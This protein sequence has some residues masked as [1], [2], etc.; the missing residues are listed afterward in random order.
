MK[1]AMSWILVLCAVALNINC[2][3]AFP[4][5]IEQENRDDG[6]MVDRDMTKVKGGFAVPV[7]DKWLFF[8]KQFRNEAAEDIQDLSDMTRIEG[9]VLALPTTRDKK[10]RRVLAEGQGTM[11]IPASKVGTVVLPIDPF[12]MGTVVFANG[13]TYAARVLIPAYNRNR[14]TIIVPRGFGVAEGKFTPA[15]GDSFYYEEGEPDGQVAAT[16]APP[17]AMRTITRSVVDLT[18]DNNGLVRPGSTNL[19]N[20]PRPRSIGGAM[21][22][23]PTL[24]DRPLGQNTRSITFR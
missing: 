11:V 17:L 15:P 2:A 21:E 7:G 19:F 14:A 3:L 16:P 1:L 8:K 12:K 9:G 18:F 24:R 10:G 13:G 5:I 20:N 4:E 6:V 22:V 23:N